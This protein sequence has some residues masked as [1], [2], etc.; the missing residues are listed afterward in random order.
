[1]FS[2]NLPVSDFNCISLFPVLHNLKVVSM[3]LLLKWSFWWTLQRRSCLVWSF[4]LM[5]S[6]WNKITF[7]Q[8][9]NF[10]SFKFIH[11]RP[12]CAC[13]CSVYLHQSLSL[14]CCCLKTFQT[15][16][17]CI[18]KKTVPKSSSVVSFLSS[19]CKPATHWYWRHICT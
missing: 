19:H 18:G 12:I 13:S 6:L 11:L 5:V 16:L 1:M 10:I 3:E 17:E 4:F 14:I 15:G 8:Y 2:G 9:M 7:K